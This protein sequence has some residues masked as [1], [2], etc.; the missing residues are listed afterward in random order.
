MVSV[1]DIVRSIQENVLGYGLGLLLLSLI[2]SAVY[3]TVKPQVDNITREIQKQFDNLSAEAQ[4]QAEN[5][6]K[7]IGIDAGLA[8]LPLP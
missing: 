8:L 2:G 4:K 5:I 6:L 7:N 3:P 1:D